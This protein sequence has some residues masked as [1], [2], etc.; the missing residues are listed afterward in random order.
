[1]KR[2]VMLMLIFIVL[3]YGME[4]YKVASKRRQEL[5]NKRIEQEKWE[6][7]Q[8]LDRTAPEEYEEWEIYANRILD[9]ANLFGFR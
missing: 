3:Y 7:Q 8:Y 1:M 4:Y 5:E 2:V 9:P 6:A